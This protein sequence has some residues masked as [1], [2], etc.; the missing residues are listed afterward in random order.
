MADAL[1]CSNCGAIL[2]REDLFCGECG[3]PRP[4]SPV[5]TELVT[6]DAPPPRVPEPEDLQPSPPSGPAPPSPAAHRPIPAPPPR[7]RGISEGWRTVSTII[8]FLA[9]SGA[10]VM[11]VV[12]ILIGFVFL[13][14]DTGQAA[15]EPLILGASLLCFCPSA[16]LIA[17]AV[18]L[19]ALVIRRK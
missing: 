3:A 9:L 18:T 15:T 7:P 14:P 1:E 13:D 11:I 4:S 10:L 8:A 2:T 19:Y 17:G 16:L 12:G 5:G 6:P